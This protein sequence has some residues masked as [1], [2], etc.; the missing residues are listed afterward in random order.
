MRITQ[1]T[2]HYLGAVWLPAITE[3]LTEFLLDGKSAATRGGGEKKVEREITV[4]HLSFFL[5]L[6]F[7]Y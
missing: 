1:I 6:T 7:K 2:A 4:T 3:S 5:I